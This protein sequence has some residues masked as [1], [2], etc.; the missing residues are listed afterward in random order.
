MQ[1]ELIASP[2]NPTAQIQEVPGHVTGPVVYDH[3]YYWPH[4]TPITKPVD[5][6]IMLFT[7]SKV[8]G[9]AGSRVGYV[10]LP[11]SVNFYDAE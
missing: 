2:N 4:L 1:I 9:H 10:F 5:H 7:L 8:T 6:D 3:A 11:S